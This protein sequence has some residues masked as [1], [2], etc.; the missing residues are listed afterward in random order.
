MTW[1]EKVEGAWTLK[2]FYTEDSLG[3]K[4]Y[5]M[6]KK[7][8]GIIMYTKDGYMSAQMMGD[9]EEMQ[10]TF[11][12]NGDGESARVQAAKGYIAY[13]GKFEVNE[14]TRT[15]YHHTDVCLN[16]AWYGQVQERS[17][18]IEG[19]ILKIHFHNGVVN[20]V[21]LWERQHT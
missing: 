16:P 9:L 4:V 14:D 10:E 1:R 20:N 7:A 3:T 13:S 11:E 6:G 18:T 21:I 5:P 2:E 15:L 12:G 17:F 8:K 19:S